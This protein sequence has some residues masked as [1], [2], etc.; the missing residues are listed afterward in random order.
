MIHKI[1]IAV[2]RSPNNGFVFD[3]AVS[4]A[5]TTGART[6]KTEQGAW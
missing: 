2:D 1:L 3:T 5:Q 4:L 6:I